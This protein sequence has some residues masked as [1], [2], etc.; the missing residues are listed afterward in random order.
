[1]QTSPVGHKAPE[2]QVNMSAEAQTS[3]QTDTSMLIKMATF[4]MNLAH[5]AAQGWGADSISV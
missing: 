3:T 5:N 2:A 4:F 1:M